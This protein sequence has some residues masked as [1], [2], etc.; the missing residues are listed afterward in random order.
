MISREEVREAL[1]G[2]IASLKTPF[3]RDGEID[4]PGLR[5][6][7]DGNLDSGSNS[8]LLTYGDSLFTLM[9]DDEIAD[10]A[11]AVAE[12]T[13]KRGLTVAAD[14][15]W[16]TGK[17]V[18]FA[19]YCREVG[20]DV[21]MVRPPVWGASGTVET[22][23]EHYAAVA[24]EIPV[25]LVTNIWAGD[26]AKGLKTIEVLLDKVDGIVAVKDDM[27]GEFVVRKMTAMAS[28]KWAVF[29]GGQKQNHLDIIHYG[30][31]GYMS[32]FV[33]FYPPVGPT[34]LERRKEW[35]LERRRESDRGGRLAVLLVHLR[36]A[37]RLRRRD[38]M[39]R[40]GMGGVRHRGDFG[41]ALRRRSGRDPGDARDQHLGRRHRQGPEDD[42]GPA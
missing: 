6:L 3:T 40:P 12:H 4:Y 1:T 5:R 29:A 33:S 35:G 30:A 25:M 32:T 27:L 37:G 10:V 24:A 38:A 34:L 39:V 31:V 15:G 21:L 42:R 26:T 22:S 16:W 18:E 28:D 8:S 19:R 41:G 20:V 7:I 36:A 23:V 13:G 11:R 17:T 2:P 14:G 9:T